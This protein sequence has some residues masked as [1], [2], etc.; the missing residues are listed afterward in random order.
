MLAWNLS[1]KAVGWIRGDSIGQVPRKEKA[2][3]KQEMQGEQR[4][5]EP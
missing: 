5:G 3:R 4:W 1:R 2:Q